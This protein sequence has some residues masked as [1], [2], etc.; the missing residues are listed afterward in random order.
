MPDDSLVD[1]QYFVGGALA[2][3]DSSTSPIPSLTD[4]NTGLTSVPS[5]P[6][7]TVSDSSMDGYFVG[8][9]AS[10]GYSNAGSALTLSA[11]A[12]GNP[13]IAPTGN[14]L[15]DSLSTQSAT[16]VNSVSSSLSTFGSF[17][18]TGLVA[19][20]SIFRPTANYQGSNPT[21][22]YTPVIAPAGSSLLNSPALL[23]GAAA[24]AAFFVLRKG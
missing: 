5:A 12:G 10:P 18:E 3:F 9:A 23:I 16:A 8:G 11:G 20:L 17:L 6:Q 14:S 22:P 1:G 2:P 13:V 15:L 21:V 4:P 7:T 19:A 24:L